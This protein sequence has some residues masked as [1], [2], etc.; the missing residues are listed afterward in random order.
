[1]HRLL[2]I[3][4]PEKT[5]FFHVISGIILVG[6]R[7]E[8]QYTIQLYMKTKPTRLLLLVTTVLAIS[9]NRNDDY[10]QV[11]EKGGQSSEPTPVATT[12]LSLYTDLSKPAS[13][14]GVF[15]IG[16]LGNGNATVE[17]QLSE[18]SRKDGAKYKTSLVAY[19][20]STKTDYEYADL[21]EVNGTT[22]VGGKTLVTMTGS[23][24]PLTFE[25]LNDFKGFRVRITNGNKVVSEG[26]IQ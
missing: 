13:E 9:C 23:T 8:D 17:V 18:S 2:L 25:A 5:N 4:Y 20:Y 11:E 10:S 1:M 6:L 14:S 7:P 16:K 3:F 22:G 21:G 26:M 15:K 12:K 24:S 19:D